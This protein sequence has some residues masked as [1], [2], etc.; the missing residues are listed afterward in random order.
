M[1]ITTK[2]I[3][4]IRALHSLYLLA[5]DNSKPVGISTLSEILSISNKYLEQIFSILRKAKLV[6]SSAGKMGGY[7]LAKPAE[8]ITILE[9][10][11]IMDGSIIPA[12]CVNESCTTCDKCVLKGLW[13]D[14][15]NNIEE[16]LKNVT[17]ASI[18][19]CSNHL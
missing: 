10:I 18:D 4:A 13:H 6:I 14:M 11:N 15:K 5:K 19:K 9:I 1:K 12:H 3:Y 17:I 7:K 2:S 8:S 16:Y